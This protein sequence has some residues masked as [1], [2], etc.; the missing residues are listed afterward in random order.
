VSTEANAI[1]RFGLTGTLGSADDIDDDWA[2]PEVTADLFVID[3]LGRPVPNAKVNVD[4]A[5]STV[6]PGHVLTACVVHATADASTTATGHTSFRSLAVSHATVKVT[7]DDP[8]LLGATVDLD[9]TSGQALVTLP[10]NP[11]PNGI[12]PVCAAAPAGLLSAWP[13]DGDLNDIAGARNGTID[14]VATYQPSQVGSGLFVSNGQR[15]TA[16]SSGLPMGN[17]SRTMEAWVRLDALN[18][19]G[20]EAFFAGYGAFGTGGGAF[21]LGATGDQP[22]V[23]QWGN[24]VVGAPLTLGAWTHLAATWD[25]TVVALYV[26]GTKVGDAP[27]TVD[28]QAGDFYMGALPNDPY[29]ILTGAV[30]EVAVYDRALSAAEIAAIVTA[31]AAGKCR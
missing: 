21:A 28:T 1:S 18:P 23:S 29:R 26:N 19:L 4:T 30:D 2:L 17:A 24:A 14:F 13:L 16:S 27:M 22:F 5:V 20:G 31:G 12:C 6:C 11:C 15:V 3:S 10:T 9:L 7:T 8:K 25:G